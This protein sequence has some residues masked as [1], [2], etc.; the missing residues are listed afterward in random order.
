MLEGCLSIRISTP[1]PSREVAAEYHLF[2]FAFLPQPCS[3]QEPIWAV[4][5]LLSWREEWGL[6]S[7][8]NFTASGPGTPYGVR[9]TPLAAK[10]FMGLGCSVVSSH[11]EVPHRHIPAHLCCI[12]PQFQCSRLLSSREPLAAQLTS[13]SLSGGVSGNIVAS[14]SSTFVKSCI[15]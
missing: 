3:S 1:I 14:H 12:Q 4:P 8:G 7:R 11:H 2:Y 10:N 9:W 13:Q 5:F 15:N 6:A